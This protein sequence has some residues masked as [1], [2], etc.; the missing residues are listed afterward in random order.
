MTHPLT[1][2]SPVVPIARLLAAPLA[3]GRHPI[4]PSPSWRRRAEHTLGPDWATGL[5]FAGPMLVLMIGLIG[6]PILQALW[7]SLHQVI[8]PRWV[9][10]IGLD[11][12]AAQLRDP[13]FGRALA[14]TLQFTAESVVIK[15]LIG[16]TAA[17]ALHNA[18][19]FRSVLTA[20]ILAPYI[21][22]EVVTAA[23]WRFLFNPQFGGLNATLLLLHTVTGG[24]IGSYEGIGWTS[25]PGW[26]L[27]A[28]V[29]VNVW[30][31][32]PFF[33]LLALA[34]LKSIDRELFDAAAVDGATAWQRF[35]HIT[36]PG[37]RYV[38]IVE[39]LFSLISTFN[40][41]GMIYL[42][43]AGGPGG[44]TKVY[45]IRVYEMI[46][47]MLF[48]RAVA[49]AMLIAPILAVLVII[50]GR[51]MRGQQSTEEDAEG[52]AYMSLMWLVWPVKVVLRFVLDGFW[53]L[54]RYLEAGF[55]K[56]GRAIGRLLTGGSARAAH[57]L[58]RTGAALLIVV[59]IVVITF[60]E[61][62]PFYW[63]VVTAFKT[64]QQIGTY[65]SVFWP[66][67]WTGEHFVWLFTKSQFPVWLRNTLIVAL[68]AT[69]ISLSVSALGAYALV[70]LRWFGAGFIST[71]ILITYLMPSIMLVVPLFQIFALFRLTN[72][73]GSLIL[74]YPIG[75]MPFACWLLMGYYRSIPEELEESALID[76]C[77]KFTSFR[78][79][80]FPLVLP[81]LVVVALFSITGA[82]NEF[83]MAFVFIQSNAA[84]T[85]PVGLGKLIIGDIFP[86]GQIM[87]ASIT[88][89]LP[90]IVFYGF[91]Q[92]FL[93]EG[94]TAGSV[95]G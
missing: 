56:V 14:V 38:I 89:S 88:M 65:T 42:I 72:T 40:T 31:G 13:L 71:A 12:Y 3:A 91:A 22:P 85:L 36:L 34:G 63:I 81:A 23:T 43:T 46:G 4:T 55:E 76:G 30:K 19:H 68:S 26:A 74:A 61:L 59:P 94:L 58:G 47:S 49:M 33:T 45:A 6:W 41:F 27:Q 53:F 7:M 80:V 11:N 73:L 84:T 17:L 64:N 83:L 25:D 51:Y 90:V 93:V 9:A 39:S 86:W 79:I 35:L 77:N 50:L 82:W 28:M 1:R 29:A 70:R 92:R 69:A 62:Y 57:R 78:Y 66:S 54:N 95:K 48:G 10:F 44:A 37:L 75:L 8:G 32:V 87:A 5:G 2:G 16:L 24:R 20:L 67:P 60:V 15:F 52:W 18:K 21:V